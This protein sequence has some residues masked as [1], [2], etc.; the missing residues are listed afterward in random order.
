MELHDLG[1]SERH[2]HLGVQ[3]LAALQHARAQHHRHG[4]LRHILDY[5][6]FV[7]A[8]SVDDRR[9]V[10][11][12]LV[13]GHARQDH[14]HAHQT[15]KNSGVARQDVGYFPNVR[16]HQLHAVVLPFRLQPRSRH[17]QRN[18]VGDREGDGQQ[19]RRAVE[20]GGHP[21]HYCQL[22]VRFHHVRVGHDYPLAPRPLETLVPHQ[23][24][25]AS[26]LADGN[27]RGG[28]RLRPLSVRHRG[29]TAV[30]L[31]PVLIGNRE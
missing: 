24:R 26:A 18:G 4:I 2:R 14:F 28:G 29:F 22:Q 25:H 31:L 17:R 20:R 6:P 10:D 7:A 9:G 16:L 5:Q 21:R 30:Y 3:D 11:R 1:R 23:L 8:P 12:H 15:R 27:H 13:C 19:H